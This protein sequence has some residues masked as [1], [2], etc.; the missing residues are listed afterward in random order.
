M[1]T[2]SVIILA[3]PKGFSI[4]FSKVS[5]YLLDKANLYREK[6]KYILKKNYETCYN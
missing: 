5:R 1:H 3:I 2:A 6:V 4:R